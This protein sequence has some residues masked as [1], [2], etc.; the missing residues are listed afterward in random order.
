MEFI[1]QNWLSLISLL[2]ALLGGIPGIIAAI[3][4]FKDK[5]D[6]YFSF[7]AINTGELINEETGQKMSDVLISGTLSNSGTQPLSPGYFTLSLDI[8]GQWRTLDRLLIPE[9]LVLHS[10]EQEISIGEPWKHDLQ[11]YTGTISKGIPLHG[12][13]M[14]VHKD[15]PIETI[16]ESL[17]KGRLIRIVCVDI[18]GKK[19]VRDITST[20]ERITTDT[21]Y[22]K[23]GI[24][25]SPKKK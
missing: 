6:F 18:F 20:S 2:I 15:I 4:H 1:E 13:L 17:E 23:H 8:N 24:E 21:T 19:H 5:P 9:N 3:T 25:V 22:P 14:F 12:F 11:R 16:R 10:H 7:D